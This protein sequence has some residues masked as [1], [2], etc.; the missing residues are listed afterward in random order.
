MNAPTDQDRKSGPPGHLSAASKRFWSAVSDSFELETHHF[1]LLRLALEA[2]D[3][4][5]NARE[6]LKKAGS[7]TFVDRFGAPHARP[8]V[9]I[10]RD[11]RLSYARLLREV[12]LDAAGTPEITRPV[13][14]RANQGGKA[15]ASS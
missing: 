4:G 11:A 2:W 13:L 12:G 9:N 10:E 7:L 3:R 8:E 1:A 5:Q 15:N 14:L 6:E